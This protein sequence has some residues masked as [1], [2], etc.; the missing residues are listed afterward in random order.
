MNLR[1][2]CLGS[3]FMTYA[4]AFSVSE[5]PAIERRVAP[6][7]SSGVVYSY[8]DSIKDAKRGVVNISTQKKVKGASG[9][10]PSHPL[11]N[12]PFFKQFFGDMFGQVIPKD[13]IER[14]L[15]SG[16]II[17]KDGYILTNNHVIDGADKVIVSLPDN[18][19]EYEA[20]VIGKDPRSDLAVI[21]I[22][23]KDFPFVIFGSSNDLR[24]GDVVF[25]IGNPF[26]VGETV[27]QG[28]VSALNKSGIGINDYENFIQTDAS[29]N[30]GNSGGALVDSRGALVGIN[31][32]IL[33]RTGGNHGVGFAI[34]SDMAKKIAIT[35][36]DKG[37]IERGYM[38]VSIQDVTQDLRDLYGDKEGAVIISTESSSPAAKAG[39][40]VW[41]LITKIDEKPV[42]NAADLKNII[43]SYSP[44]DKVKVTYIRDKKEST[45]TLKLIE[46]PSNA[47]TSGAGTSNSAIDGLML[48]A[49]DDRIRQRYR[50]AI[51]TSGV[52]VIGVQA[53]S[54]AEEIGFSEGDIILQIENY[55]IKDIASFNEAM[56]QH[57][58]KA[59]RLLVSRGGTIFSVVV[60]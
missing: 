34:P 31:T 1:L 5:A 46:A 27:T 14:S 21:K 30:P 19:K 51:D 2:F 16:V 42:K 9:I 24:V 59:K 48:S 37:V 52:L 17:S 49:I 8:Y 20:K 56:K 60:K 3:L 15:G 25:A 33:S 50:L 35:L 10:D 53:G 11:F 26:G 38:G 54:Y 47:K 28:I 4:L 44:N 6:D 18:S 58:G 32:A 7:V 23:G 57:K 45:A 39:L 13:R 36:I 12:D 29:I 41:D 55:P 43:G 22:E 40:K